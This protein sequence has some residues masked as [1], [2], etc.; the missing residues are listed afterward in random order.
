[1][2]IIQTPARF[3]PFIGGVEN[4]VRDLSKELVKNGHDVIV[5]CA[6]EPTSPKKRDNIDGIKIE[7]LGYIGKIAN[8][9]VTQFLPFKLLFED[10][11]VIHT[12]LPTPWSADWSA[13]IA[14]LRRKKLIVTYH[15]DIVGK[16][17]TSII[18]KIYNA[19]LLK[20]VLGV[21]HKIIITQP[22]YLDYSPSLKKYKDK[23]VVIPVGVDTDRFKPMKVKKEP[24]TVGFLAVLDEYH[25]YKGLDYLL[26]AI[27]QV[28]EKVHDVKL[29]V[30]GSG[31]LLPEYK[32]M[33]DEL[34]ISQ[35]V[36]FFGFVPDDKLVEFY[37]KL[38]VFVLPSTS[39]EQEGFGTVL[40]EALACGTPV[41]TTE[42]AGIAD[43]IAENGLGVVIKPRNECGLA[44]ALEHIYT[45]KTIP[46]KNV[47]WLESKYSLDIISLKLK[48]V[49]G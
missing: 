5:I 48:Q 17:F 34:G 12:H 42:I 2:K 27:A 26:K 6:N 20:I 15:N 33:A 44:G 35:S 38:D 47:T 21:A 9:N 8:T 3:Y 14:F 24:H 11:D 45:T 41:I 37:N 49:F 4:Y 10:F 46:V 29:L 31:A 16:G 40:L 18:A 28:K 30:G 32:K 13:I 43:E 19:T 36:E 39:S 22:K 25:R 23:I 1:M 7:R